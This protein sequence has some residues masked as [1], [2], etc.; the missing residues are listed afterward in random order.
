MF[1]LGEKRGQELTFGT[2]ADYEN[3]EPGV[4]IFGDDQIFK[5]VEEKVITNKKPSSGSSEAEKSDYCNKLKI[6][7]TFNEINK[8][9]KILDKYKGL[10]DLKAEYNRTHPKRWLIALIIG[11]LLET[12]ILVVQSLYGGGFNPIIILFAFMLAIGG[13]LLGQWLE[14]LFYVSEHRNV[15]QS[16]EGVEK[17]NFMKVFLGLVGIILIIFVATVRSISDE[18]GID[19]LVF[20]ITVILGLM[21]A[22]LEGVREYSVHKLKDLIEYRRIY[23]R[24]IATK[25]HCQ[26]KD[27]YLLNE[28]SENIKNEIENDCKIIVESIEK[29]LNNLKKGE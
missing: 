20:S 6:Y 17:Q 3:L 4:D 18:E 14:F 19:V 15:S 10:N 16:S 26:N 8:L 9:E 21:V 11:I 25:M 23:L 27:K 2:R 13:I 5:K 29:Y 28:C 24:A 22:T 12:S 1:G 7:F